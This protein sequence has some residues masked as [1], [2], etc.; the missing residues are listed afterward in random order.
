MQLLRFVNVAVDLAMSEMIQD[1]QDINDDKSGYLWV[2][3]ERRR[4]E[5]PEYVI[6][7]A[8][9]LRGLFV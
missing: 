4:S 3:S 9:D 7:K 6:R 2:K 1:G 5:L 8:P